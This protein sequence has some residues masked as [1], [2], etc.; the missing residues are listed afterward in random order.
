MVSHTA[1]TCDYGA[2]SSLHP[3][4]VKGWAEHRQTGATH[5]HQPPPKHESSRTRLRKKDPGRTSPALILFTA[6][7]SILPSKN[8]LTTLTVAQS[9]C[10]GNSFFLIHSEC[11]YVHTITWLVRL[12]ITVVFPIRLSLKE[13]QWRQTLSSYSHIMTKPRRMS[14]SY[15]VKKD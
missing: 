14:C 6:T 10:S 5:T 9:E 13:K 7:S 8:T 4:M 3:E 15:I 12:I 11:H 1:I 2:R